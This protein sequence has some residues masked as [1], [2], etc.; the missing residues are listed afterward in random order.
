M[1]EI[2][3]PLTAQLYLENVFKLHGLPSDIVSDRGS[4]FTSR[5]WTR[6]MELLNVKL[7]MSTAYHPQSDG[8]T[9]RVNQVLEQYLRFYCDYQQDDWSSLLP[10]AEFS[11]NNSSHSATKMSPFMANFGYHPVFSLSAPQNTAQVPAAESLITN[12]KNT[13]IH[14]VE[15]IK[16][17]VKSYEKFYNKKVMQQPDFPIDSKVWLIRRNITTTRPSSK[18]DY[19]KLGPFKIIKKVGN[20]AYKLELPE[21]IKIHPV[22]HVSLLEPVIEDNIPGRAH[23][24]PLPVM[25]NNSEEYEIEQILDS[26]LY[27][28]KL[29][30]LVDWKGYDPSARSWEPVEN[31]D[32]SI[33][34]IREFHERY[35]NKPSVKNFCGNILA[36]ARP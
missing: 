4:V 7:N 12:L 10:L 26:R 18:L 30:Y 22:F 33:E 15:N 11:Y 1:N 21:N 36:G 24:L 13:H 29:Q 9:E 28:R 5:F 34:L 19:T 17:A 8:Q 23:E 32:N 27:R 14:L 31:L 20:R 6:L 3:A 2:D 25:I 16:T 35:P